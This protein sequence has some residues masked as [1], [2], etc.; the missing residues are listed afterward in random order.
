MDVR[1]L[2]SVQAVLKEG[3]FLQAAR[4]LGYSQSTI[5][6]HIQELEEELGLALFIRRGRHTRPTEAARVLGERAE[7]VLG[8]LHALR[9]SMEELRE[10]AGGLLRIGAI[11]PAASQ[12]LMLV[13]GR[14]CRERPALRLR[15]EV[16]GS[17]AISGRV[18]AGGLDIGLCSLPDAELG[19]LFEPLFEERMALLLPE[20]HA[21]T[22]SRTIRARD[23]EEVRLLLTEQ[24]CAY[25]RAIR[26]A[27]QERGSLPDCGLEIGSTAA[28]RQAVAQGL[29]V[30]LV[31]VC[32]SSPLPEGTVLRELSDVDV[33]LQVG[34]VRRDE[35]PPPTRALEALIAA[36]RSAPELADPPGGASLAK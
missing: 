6:L 3:S 28:L 13:L 14:L 16:G 2:V 1:H 34:L 9:R 25:R 10:G 12:R 24:G 35:G 30:A 26:S 19:L 5:T 29:G 4:A 11:E 17:G 27:L 33:S 31:P 15:L 7:Q 36:L 21:L 8:G 18:A 32:G 20:R 22:R 23:L